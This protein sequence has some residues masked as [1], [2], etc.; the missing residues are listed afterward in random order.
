MLEEYGDENISAVLSNQDMLSYLV[1]DTLIIV[2]LAYIALLPVC[3]DFVQKYLPNADGA[4]ISIALLAGFILMYRVFYEK[5]RF[6]LWATEG[7]CERPA[8][9]SEAY[10][11]LMQRQGQGQGQ[12]PEDMTTQVVPAGPAVSLPEAMDASG[13]GYAPF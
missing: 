12:G 3:V 4:L 9:L 1:M 10:Q 7:Y 2:G 6:T 11:P 5:R 13:G 8:T